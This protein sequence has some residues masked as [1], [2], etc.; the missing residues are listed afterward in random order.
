MYRKLKDVSKEELIQAI[1]E[2][3]YLGSVLKMLGCV[4]NTYNRNKLKE[5]IEDND[6]STTHIK[7]RVTREIYEKNP[8][9]CKYCGEL[10][11]FEKRD[12][13]FCNHSCAASYNNQGVCRNGTSSQ[14]NYC[15]NCGK[16][17]SKRNKFCNNVCQAEYYYKQYIE[18]W[19]T[20][21]ES[22]T[23]STDDISNYV[24]KY[25]FE[26]HNNS[27][28][29]CGWNEVNPYTGRVPLQI[30]HL[31]GDCKN[32]RPENLQLLCPNCH[33]LTENFGSRNRN[34]TRID[35]RVR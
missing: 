8:K 22:G 30:H 26:I 19:K 2:A 4:D 33:S 21:E 16:E 29:K 10:L 18:K 9:Y 1:E 25:L 17:I 23:I 24:R 12:N 31:D 7:N 34:C 20:G 32:N 14:P 11:P 6:I 15:L 28:E 35:K 27:C 5:F 13:D 3:E